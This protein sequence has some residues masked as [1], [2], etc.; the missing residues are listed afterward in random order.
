MRYLVYQ[1]GDDAA[2]HPGE[3]EPS[4]QPHTG[5][6]AQRSKSLAVAVTVVEQVTPDPIIEQPDR[7][8]GTDGAGGEDE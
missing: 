4:A 5:R 3:A 1:P 7:E 2:C 8:R 6:D